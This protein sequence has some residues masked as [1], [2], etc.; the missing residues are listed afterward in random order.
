MPTAQNSQVNG[1]STAVDANT[2]VTPTAILNSASSGAASNTIATLI[3]PSSNPSTTGTSKASV[4]DPSSGPSDSPAPPSTTVPQVVVTTL[5]SISTT[6]P[7]TESA[8]P[9]STSAAA[10]STTDNL[11]PESAT[12]HTS[13]ASSTV[14]ATQALSPSSAPS[15]APANGSS[16]A[17][18]T[19]KGIS[20]A[21]AIGGGVGGG[22]VL[23]LLLLMAAL[24]YRQ[25]RRRDNDLL[26]QPLDDETLAGEVRSLLDQIG[27]HVDNVYARKEMQLTKDM[28]DALASVDTNLLPSAL[29]DMM[30]IPAL[31]GQD[32]IASLIP[33]H[34]AVLPSRNGAQG[35]EKR[36]DALQQAYSQ[37]RVLT[38]YLFPDSRN[39]ELAKSERYKATTDIVNTVSTAFA[40]WENDQEVEGSAKDHLGRLTELASSIGLMLSS[41]ASSLQF[42]WRV[43]S[44]HARDEGAEYMV[45]L[46][47]LSKLSDERGIGLRHA[48]TIVRPV[49]QKI[50][51]RAWSKWTSRDMN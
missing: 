21:A 10:S 9:S 22:V 15:S 43:S 51:D 27:L 48:Q 31:Q 28:L 4:T 1:D 37:W 40:K 19:K 25:K 2:I 47:G 5:V 20:N 42:T 11:A 46:P 50:R 16:P 18:V 14:G 36:A 41:Q 33:P 32:S 29:P 49:T 30:Q 7:T 6:T 23:L 12:I 26:P 17:G 13:T 24:I 39:E 44:R 34:I 35:E 45:V 38:A 3:E 8:I